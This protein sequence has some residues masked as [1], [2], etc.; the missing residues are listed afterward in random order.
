MQLY[1]LFL[2]GGEGKGVIREGWKGEGSTALKK[3]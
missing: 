3:R 1:S 2:W